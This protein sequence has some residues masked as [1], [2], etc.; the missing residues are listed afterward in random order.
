MI[1]GLD[2]H[3]ISLSHRFK[4]HKNESSYKLDSAMIRSEQHVLSGSE[5]GRVVVYDLLSSALVRSL[6]HPNCTV[7]HRYVV[8]CEYGN[9]SNCSVS[10]HP[11]K[12]SVLSASGSNVYLWIAHEEEQ[13]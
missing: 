7:V 12:C 10:A 2:R 6:R 1:L 9:K 13:Q 11:T 5:D 3:I 4:G 8:C